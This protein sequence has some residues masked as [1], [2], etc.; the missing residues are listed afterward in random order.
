MTMKPQLTPQALDDRLGGYLYPVGTRLDLSCSGPGS[1]APRLL[2]RR[3]IFYGAAGSIGAMR[4]CSEV[5]SGWQNSASQVSWRPGELLTPTC[6]LASGSGSE[7]GLRAH[8]MS[9]K[10][11]WASRGEGCKVAFKA[12]S[13]MEG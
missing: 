6:P 8:V 9:W 5:E 1:V 13:A 7:G 11:S 12:H 3:P 10:L 2:S 4:K